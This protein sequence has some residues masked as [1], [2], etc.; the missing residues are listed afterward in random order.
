MGQVMKKDDYEPS[1]QRA[2][3]VAIIHCPS[4]IFGAVSH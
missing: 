4:V 3:N 1:K 2:S